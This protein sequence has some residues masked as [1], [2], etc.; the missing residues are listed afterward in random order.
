MTDPEIMT[1]EELT[2]FEQ[3]LANEGQLISIEMD[4]L[5]NKA[6]TSLKR[7]YGSLDKAKEEI[8]Q[9]RRQR[10]ELQFMHEPVIGDDPDDDDPP[11]TNPEGH[12][13]VCTGTGYGGDDE[14]FFGEGRMYCTWCG[15]DGDG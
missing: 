6:V 9:L 8:E 15:K 10:D 3:L 13:W 2:R 11:C 4:R 1:D 5:V 12:E 7:T 14:R